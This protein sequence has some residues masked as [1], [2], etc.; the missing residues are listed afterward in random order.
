[1]NDYYKMSFLV[2]TAGAH[3]NNFRY[4]IHTAK[5]P[6]LKMGLR[7]TKEIVFR[8]DKN[9]KV[10]FLDS[11]RWLFSVYNADDVKQFLRRGMM[12]EISEEDVF[13]HLL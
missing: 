3:A 6:A 4:F 7:K 11:G 2:E 5:E 13:L 12:K 9:G 10:D 1:M 8:M